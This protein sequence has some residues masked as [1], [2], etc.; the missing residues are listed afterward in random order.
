[1]HP[2]GETTPS[3]DAT[4]IGPA[5]DLKGRVAIVTG[6]GQ[7][8]GRAFAKAFAACGAIAVIAEINDATATSVAREIEGTHGRALALETDVS[9]YVSVERSVERVREAFGRIDILVNN[10]AIFSSLKMRGF[11]EIPLDEW[12]RVFQVNVTGVFNCCRAVAPLMREARW[13]RIINISSG[14]LMLGRPRYLH[15]STSKAALIGMSRSLAR[16]LGPFGVTVN[17]LLPGATFTEIPRET[18]TEDEKRA[19]IA[20]Q[21]IPRASTAD[22]L[23]GPILF[24]ASEGARFVTGA[25]ILV[26][27]GASFL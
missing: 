22:D 10:A 27:G 4:A 25:S 2:L 9:D 12:E 24:L 6:A 16:E 8:L 17:C 7:G 15:Y 21:C 19:I 18:V 3:I 26:D 20:S 13:G 5:A 23:I 14:S 1:M 11:D